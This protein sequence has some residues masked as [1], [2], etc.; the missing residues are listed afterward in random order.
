MCKCSSV[1]KLYAVRSGAFEIGLRDSAHVTQSIQGMPARLLQGRF[2]F[3][4]RPWL[5]ASWSGGLRL[6]PSANQPAAERMQALRASKGLEVLAPWPWD[7]L[8]RLH[9]SGYSFC[10]ACKF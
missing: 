10:E 5:T 3:L 6:N 8:V 1:R 4:L 9:A 7:G 2:P